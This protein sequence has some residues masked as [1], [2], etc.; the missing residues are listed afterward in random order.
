MAVSAAVSLAGAR[1]VAGRWGGGDGDFHV[2]AGSTWLVG[3]D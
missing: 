3:T 2:V 1:V